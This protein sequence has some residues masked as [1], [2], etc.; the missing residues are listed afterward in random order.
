MRPRNGDQNNG[1]AVYILK[2]NKI[3]DATAE[4]ARNINSF[5]WMPDGKSLLLTGEKGTRSV[6]WNQPVNGEAAVLNLGD[7]NC[8]NKP[9][10][11]KTE[12]LHL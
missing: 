7:V 3:V 6:I 10:V 2:E 1:N 9:G 11:S 5:V 4:L 12:R 8:M